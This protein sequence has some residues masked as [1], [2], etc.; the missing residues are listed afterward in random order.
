MYHEKLLSL[1]SEDTGKYHR[2]LYK[3][4]SSVL[5]VAGERSV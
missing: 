3:M 1:N 5:Y 2:S 4:L